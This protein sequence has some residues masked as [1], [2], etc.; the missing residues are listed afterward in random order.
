M[1]GSLNV[2][3]IDI[4]FSS[5]ISLLIISIALVPKKGRD[6]VI[7]EGMDEVVVVEEA[8][9]DVEEATP[10]NTEDE[11]ED[12]ELEEDVDDEDVDGEDEEAVAVVEELEEEEEF[13]D[14][15]ELEKALIVV[16][17]DEVVEEELEDEELSPIEPDDEVVGVVPIDDITSFSLPFII[18]SLLL[19]TVSF[20][21]DGGDTYISQSLYLIL[22][23]SVGNLSGRRSFLK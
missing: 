1:A 13:E 2:G 3:N 5:D 18:S 17:E 14:D 8:P 12:E 4:S 22:S 20:T 21:T 6:T 10:D 9:D 19:S 11:D 7:D 15:E 23:S 16:E